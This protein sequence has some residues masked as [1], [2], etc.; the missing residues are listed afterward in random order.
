MY[1][2]PHLATNDQNV[3][4]SESGLAMPVLGG[5]LRESWVLL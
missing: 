3:P 5:P 1:V 4:A 2:V